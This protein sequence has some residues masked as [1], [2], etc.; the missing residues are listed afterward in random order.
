MAFSSV[1]RSAARAGRA[2]LASWAEDTADRP[3]GIAGAGTAEEGSRPAG[4]STGYPGGTGTRRP[5][6]GR[7]DTGPGHTDSIRRDP[8]RKDHREETSLPN[9]P[10]F[11]RRLPRR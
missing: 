8:D 7:P 10:H 5:A 11:R 2:H 9:H 1:A 4:T 3:A 6:A